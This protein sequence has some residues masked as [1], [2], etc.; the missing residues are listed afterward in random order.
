VEQLAS[1]MDNLRTMAAVVAQDVK[2]FK[3]SE[4]EG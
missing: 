4:G 2:K 3:I 1:T